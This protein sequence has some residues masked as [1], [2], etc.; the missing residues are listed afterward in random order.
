MELLPVKITTI[1]SHYIH[2]G[3]CEGR[4]ECAV[5]A[6]HWGALLESGRMCSP[7]REEGRAFQAGAEVKMGW[8]AAPR[9]PQKICFDESGDVLGNFIESIS[10]SLLLDIH[11]NLHAT[12]LGK[13]GIYRLFINYWQN[14]KIHTLERSYLWCSRE[15]G[16]GRE[17]RTIILVRI[18]LSSKDHK[19]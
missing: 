14:M 6:W 13:E 18:L 2:C 17:I 5:G 15:Y 3:D 1:Q 4:V 11:R 7:R 19:L 8:W 12:L 10:Q 16:K 9:G